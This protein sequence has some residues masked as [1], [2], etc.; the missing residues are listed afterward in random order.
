MTSETRTFIE[1]TDVS[2]IEIECSYCHIKS[3]FPISECSKIDA[4]CPHCEKKWFDSNENA[5]DKTVCPAADNLRAVAAN[6]R[7]LGGVRT[8]VHAK[9]RVYLSI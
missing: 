9:I 6:L 7:L 2:G 4:R 3:L 5:Q 1:T 8:D